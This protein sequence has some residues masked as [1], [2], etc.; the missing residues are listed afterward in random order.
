MTVQI[1]YLGGSGV[2][3]QSTLLSSDTG[4]TVWDC[5]GW[6]IEDNIG[7]PVQK[8]Q[9]S[10]ASSQA[11]RPLPSPSDGTVPV[12]TTLRDPI[13]KELGVLYPDHT[14]SKTQFT[15]WTKADYDAGSTSNVE[16]PTTDDHVGSYF[17]RLPRP[18]YHSI[19]RQ[20][21][22]ANGST[23]GDKLAARQGD[24]YADAPTITHLDAA[25]RTILT[26]TGKCA[27]TRHARVD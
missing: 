9:P 26:E 3:M 12:K 27:E 19:W 1:T 18:L 21:R 6:V 7:E 11:Y 22:M 24:V 2:G 15:P 14:W 5:D 16:D 23:A 25:G 8:F 20:K 17:E 4:R 10:R 13:G